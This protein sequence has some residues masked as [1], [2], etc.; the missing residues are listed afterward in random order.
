MA[1]LLY[2]IGASLAVLAL[3]C[4]SALA[5][6]TI[7]IGGAG[8][9]CY[10]P[11]VL[12]EQLGEYK[13]AG[14]EIELVNFKGGS[15]ALTAVIG[16]SA[17]VVSGYYDHCVN[18]AAK[19]QNLQAFV[20]YDRYPGLVLGVSPR[21]TAEINSLRDL[22]GKK[23][24]VSAPGSST[25]FFLKFLLAK[26]GV[27][28]DSVAVIGIGLDATAVAAMEQGTVDAAVMLDP[29]PTL[30]RAKFPAPKILSDTRTQADTLAVFGG[31]YPGGALYTRGD[32]IARHEK[33]TQALTDAILATLKWVHSHTPEEI[34]AKMPED[35]VG[36]DKALYLAALKNTLPMYSTTGR[37]DPKGAEAVLSVFSQSSPEVA[38]AKI[39][40]AKTY[41]NKFVERAAEKLGMR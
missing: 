1:K 41:T 14:V 17:D 37:M 25:D 19:N 15:Q 2:Q 30:L 8:C 33:E 24:G 11:T 21:H 6:I 35:L 9:L 39:D 13:K 31:E 7:A 32:W 18:L 34:L 20:V 10:L 27:A 29:T 23:V 3:A 16:G 36:P 28:P 22:A 38:K 4:G 12:A 26:N 40:L 5:K